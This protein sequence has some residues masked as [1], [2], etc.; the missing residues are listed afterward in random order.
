MTAWKQSRLIR[1]EGARAPLPNYVDGVIQYRSGDWLIEKDR[2]RHYTL[3]L[4]LTLVGSFNRLREAKAAVDAFVNSWATRVGRSDPFQIVIESDDDDKRIVVTD[5]RNR[6]EGFE[7]E[8]SHRSGC[9][10]AVKML[11]RDTFYEAVTAGLGL[12]FNPEPSLADRL[13]AEIEGRKYK[14]GAS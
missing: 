8:V 9:R 2:D 11:Y 3:Y 12:T 6:D 10:V 13:V 1:C 5:L 14:A 7:T 4:N